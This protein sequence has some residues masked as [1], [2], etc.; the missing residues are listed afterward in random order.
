LYTYFV[1]PWVTEKDRRFAV[2]KEVEFKDS[3]LYHSMRPMKQI[4]YGEFSWIVQGYCEN[5]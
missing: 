3:I 1:E 2:D 4:M 5:L